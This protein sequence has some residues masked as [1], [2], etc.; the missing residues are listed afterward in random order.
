MAPRVDSGDVDRTVLHGAAVAE[1]MA[2]V[3][4]HRFSFW[5][6]S[7]FVGGVPSP[8][9]RVAGEN[10]SPA[11]SRRSRGEGTPPTFSNGLKADQTSA[12]K[13]R[14]TL[15]LLLAVVFAALVPVASAAP[16]VEAR[17]GRV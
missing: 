9:I 7:A 4:N 5:T 11:G 8:R 12:E 17:G 15:R 2:F 16:A 6:Q 10:A 1:T 13:P 3:V 14:T